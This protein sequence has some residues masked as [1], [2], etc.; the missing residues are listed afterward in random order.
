[1]AEQQVKKELPPI[2]RQKTDFENGMIS[3]SAFQA[4]RRKQRELDAKMKAY[5]AKARAEV[6]ADSAKEVKGKEVKK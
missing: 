3:K 1:M 4:K 2:V 5:E 6:E